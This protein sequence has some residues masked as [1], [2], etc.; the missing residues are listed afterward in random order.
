MGAFTIKQ[1]IIMKATLYNLILWMLRLIIIAAFIPIIFMLLKL[2]TSISIFRELPLFH[3]F[4]LF[5]SSI[6]IFISGLLLV[7]FFKKTDKKIG[8][9]LMIIAVLW[10]IY[11]LYALNSERF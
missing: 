8:V 7:I 6:I 2:E 5:Y 11:I 3:Q 9:F 10:E 1:Q 4:H